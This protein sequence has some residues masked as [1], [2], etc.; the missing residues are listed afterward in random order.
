MHTPVA[1]SAIHRK[2]PIVPI[3]ER[4]ITSHEQLPPHLR[5]QADTLPPYLPTKDAQ[6]LAGRGR[7]L[8][9]EHAAEGRIKAVKNGAAILWETL[10]ILIDLANLPPAT[11]SLPPRRE[12]KR[13]PPAPTAAAQVEQH[14]EPAE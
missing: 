2:I 13:A 7:S 1:R 14:L 5:H 3:C 11:L 4:R 12:T 6:K 10:S 8:M 9:Y